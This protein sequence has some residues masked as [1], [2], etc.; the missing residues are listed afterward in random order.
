MLGA[1]GQRRAVVHAA[2]ADR[3]WRRF[4]DFV[5]E[6]QSFN[7][8]R[9]RGGLGRAPRL[10]PDLDSQRSPTMDTSHSMLSHLRSKP[11]RRQNRSRCRRISR[12]IS[13]RCSAPYRRSARGL[14]SALRKRAAKG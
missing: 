1:R 7:R 8:R 11:R 2:R 13:T 12:R 10:D 3:A 14:A 6:L 9:D 5:R 4:D